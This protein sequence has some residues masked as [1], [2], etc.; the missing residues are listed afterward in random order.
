VQI[1]VSRRATGAI[2]FELIQI[3]LVSSL[4]V[5]STRVPRLVS[6]RPLSSDSWDIA[7]VPVL[8]YCMCQVSR[9]WILK[10]D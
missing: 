3:G 2:D 4:T 6:T 9:L 5:R 7:S 1:S 10:T 8:H